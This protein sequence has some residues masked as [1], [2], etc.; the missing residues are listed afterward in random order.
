M[1]IYGIHVLFVRISFA[2]QL[3]SI[4][5]QQSNDTVRAGSE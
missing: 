1:K 5:D 2:E 3:Y 4:R